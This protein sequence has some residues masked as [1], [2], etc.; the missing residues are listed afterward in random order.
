MGEWL[1]EWRR[2][3]LVRLIRDSEYERR[4]WGWSHTPSDSARHRRAEARWARKLERL[5]PPSE[6]WLDE[7]GLR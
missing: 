3:R 2:R 6:D 5:G 4:K 7:T 1:R